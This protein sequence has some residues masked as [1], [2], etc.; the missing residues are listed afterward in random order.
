MEVLLL[1]TGAADGIPNVFCRCE[2]CTDYRLRGELRTPTSVLV[3]GRL[4]IDPGPEAPRQ[5]TRYGRDLTGLKAILAGHA[6]DDHLDPSL[7]M[8]RSWVSSAPLEVAGPEPVINITSKWLDPAQRAVRMRPLTAGDQVELAGYQ[9][10]ALAANHHAFGEAL[11]YWISD[12]SSA[13]L[14]LTDTGRL[15]AATLD[16]LIG[17]RADLVLLEETF[18][19]VTDRSEQ[20]HHLHSFAETISE[21]RSRGI[22]DASSRVVAIHLGHDNPPL[23]Q[24]RDQLALSGAEALPDGTL[25]VL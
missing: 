4:L 18:G 10:R 21:L 3:D 20:H 23:G 5:V 7:L 11:C 12:G 22:V 9:V 2:T 14:Y 25:I 13:L 24:L 1:G 17:C 16:S 15:S 8:H 19:Y 6:H